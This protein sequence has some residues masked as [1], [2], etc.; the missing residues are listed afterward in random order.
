MKL[1]HAVIAV[2]AVLGAPSIGWALPPALEVQQVAATGSMPKGATLSPDG[3]R[4]YVTNF[5]QRDARNISVFDSSSLTL[6]D[7]INV[8][9]TVVETVLSKNGATLYASNFARH[10]VQV[11]DVATKT[12]KAEVST[13][14]HPKILVLSPDQ[15]WLF[16][17]NWAGNSVTQIDVATMQS[18][19]T[20]PVGVHPRGTVMTSSGKLFVANFDG[21]SIDV[22]EGSDF[23][24]HHRFATCMIPRHLALSP[25]DKTLYVSCFHD[26]T[27]HA[28]D[29]ATET[30]LHRVA[31]GNSPKSIEVSRDGRY[32]WSADFGKETNSVSVVD[33]TDWTARVFTVPGMDRGSGIA[34]APD[35]KHAAVTGW[36]DNHVYLVGFAGTGGNPRA[37][38]QRIQEWINLPKHDAAPH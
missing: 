30:I 37:A 5:G 27:I 28:I 12:V 2:I 26:S 1:R 3:K 6:I 24:R 34:V 36:W 13:G 10:S 14:T 8:P 25:D 19:R 35:G 29:V 17:A 16:A 20:L 15:K 38:T 31:I 21:A 18:V 22:F 4:Y 33:T 23:S 7:T 32:V 9:G 11:I